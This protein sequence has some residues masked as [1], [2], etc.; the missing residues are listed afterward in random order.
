M[1]DAPIGV[2]DGTPLPF[3]GFT[4]API[5]FTVLA[6]VELIIGQLP[7]TPSRTV[8]MQF[9]ARLVLGGFSGGDSRRGADRHGVAL[10]YFRKM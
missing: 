9:G 2:C 4:A 7:R 3:L 10:M 6:I 1:T 8:P 5:I